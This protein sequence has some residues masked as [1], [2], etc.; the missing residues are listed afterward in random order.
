MIE[1]SEGNQFVWIPVDD[2]TTMYT[3]VSSETTLNGVTTTTNVYS[4]L[5]LRDGNSYSIG[6]PGT[7]VLRELDVLSTID[8]G[9]YNL[10]GYSSIQEM[11]DGM[12]EEYLATY[13]SIIE[14]GGFYIGRYE[15][16]G[17]EDNPTCQ[18][19]LTAFTGNCSEYTQEAYSTTQRIVRGGDCSYEGDEAPASDRNN[20]SPYTTI[21]TVGSVENSS[22]PAL[23]IK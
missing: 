11:A 19:G 2:Y 13:N 18:Q 6:T 7:T 22:R 17:D 10:L 23:Y 9:Y 4:S 1:D 14:Y 16:T 8:T 21:I 5:R 20:K 12:L 3:E 15:I